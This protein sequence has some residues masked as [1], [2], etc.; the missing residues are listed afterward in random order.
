MRALPSVSVQRRVRTGWL[1]AARELRRW[2]GAALGARAAGG[3]ISVLLVGAARSRALN[4]HY[5]GRDRPTNVLSFPTAG[6]VR[7]RGLLGDLVICP[8][9]LRTEA[10]SQRKSARA[11][12]AH[13]VVHGV[14][15]LAGYDHELQR[16]AR[17]MQR[18][19]IRVLRDLGIANPYRAPAPRCSAGGQ[20]RGR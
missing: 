20:R 1:P 8:A 4:A 9:V 6:V 11:H 14:L 13:L 19:E 3:E 5:R 16:D 18:R 15:H 12:W 10:R 2:A 7:A 17:R